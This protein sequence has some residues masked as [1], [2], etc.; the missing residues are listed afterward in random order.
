[1]E[2]GNLSNVK[3]KVGLKVISTEE[4]QEIFDKNPLKGQNDDDEI[5]VEIN[6]EKQVKFIS[7]FIF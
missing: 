4:C 6:A 3:R 1:M 5:T 7:F 2:S